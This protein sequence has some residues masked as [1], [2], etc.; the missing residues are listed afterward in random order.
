M[1]RW[2]FILIPGEIMSDFIFR[3][4][5]KKIDQ[6]VQEVIKRESERQI[7]KLIMIPSES[8]APEA[9]RECL[10]SIFQNLYAEGY[11]DDETRLLDEKDILDFTSR[12][13]HFRRFS[14]PRYYKGVEFADIIEALARRRC[15]EVFATP[16]ISA[17]ELYVN[18]QPLSG[19]PA[20]NAVYQ[21]LIQP[22]DTIMG[23]NLLHGGHLTHG[24]SVNRSG[25]LYKVI[26]Y[27]V[28]AETEQID[29]DSLAKL[30]L[31]T[32]PKVIIAGYSSYPWVPDWK[33]FREIADS[34]GAYILADVSHIAGLIAANLVPSPVGFADVITFTTHKTLCG[35]RGACILTTNDALS[36]KIDK[37]VFPG[38][39]GGPHVNVIAAMAV[40]FKLAKTAQFKNLQRTILENCQTLIKQLQNRGLRIAYG[41]SN[42]HL[43][44]IDCKS[45]KNIDGVTLSGDMAAR[46]LDLV[47]IV[48]NANTIPGDKVTAQASGIRLGTPW[49]SQRGLKSVEVN[50]VADI[51]ADVLFAC[52]PYQV[53]GKSGISNRAKI[54]YRIFENAKIRVRE[55]IEK[56]IPPNKEQ[57]KLVYPFFFF[58]DDQSLF[59]KSGKTKESGKIKKSVANAVIEI[60]GEHARQFVNFAFSADINNLKTNHGINSNLI[61]PEGIVKGQLV[62]INPHCFQFV[63]PVKNFGLVSSWLRDLSDGYIAF[64]EDLFRRLPGPVSITE[65]S[66][67]KTIKLIK[68]ESINLKPY[69]IGIS[70]RLETKLSKFK[71]EPQNESSIR[72]TPLFEIHQQLKAKIIPFAGW[73]MPVWYT[74][75]IEEHLAVRQA[76]GLFDVAHMGVYQAE[77]P[78]ACPFLDCVCANDISNLA[79]GESCYTHF[80]DPDAD[81]IDDLLVYRHQTE[82]Y[83]VV[84]NASNDDKD[85]AWLNAVKSGNVLVDRSKPW[86]QSFGRKVILRNLRDPREGKD[87][88]VDLALQGPKS[89]DILLSLPWDE[90]SRRKI[91]RL[92][93]TQLCTVKFQDFDLIVSRTG[94]TGEKIAYELFLHPS[95]LV[96][97]WNLL[98]QYGKSYGLKPCG[99]GARDSL[100]TE[101]GLP[102]YGHEMGGELNLNVAD[103]GFGS[104]VKIYKPWFIGRESFINR[105]KNRKGTVARFRFVEQHVRMAHLGDE[106]W[107]ASGKV[108]GKVTSCAIDTQGFLTGQAYLPNEMSKENQKIFI[109]QQVK[110]QADQRNIN[111]KPGERG[112]TPDEAI[113]VSRFPK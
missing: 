103:A 5:L 75:V 19:A 89:R 73:E 3:N 106:V 15:A 35:P 51:I 48:T 46:I 13:N 60:Q 68:D 99:L 98:M 37:A 14:D 23:M 85:W 52:E 43:A 76:A 17:D 11:P 1:N 110:K 26:H 20:N 21:A 58:K 65:K 100:R 87:M 112:S 47:G 31:D 53:E 63:F 84:V 54:D 42:T 74:S 80:L 10:G 105:E 93:R 62:L 59:S 6:Q 32:K 36:K 38:E 12:I 39:Q 55:V 57:E 94:Y 102:L 70:D 111:L 25:K 96:E 29:Y 78:D 67:G 33:R 79:V 109:Y 27:N 45:V 56:F 90:V 113:V 49:I 95:K 107:D 4:G 40:T 41:G 77:G 8:E 30:A 2:F 81:V 24:S 28:N 86:A 7:H 71:W 61:T 104:Y 108:I 83:L 92:N 50:K 101:A 91:N 16:I 88:R 18:V 44:N 9:V 22:G 72:R 97:F 82:K 64:D 69:F 34:I 66:A